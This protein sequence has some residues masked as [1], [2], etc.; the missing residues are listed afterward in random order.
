MERNWFSGVVGFQEF[1]FQKPKS[2]VV[3][4]FHQSSNAQEENAFE[5]NSKSKNTLMFVL[6]TLYPKR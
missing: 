3:G 1:K 2:L 6:D 4:Q 5:L